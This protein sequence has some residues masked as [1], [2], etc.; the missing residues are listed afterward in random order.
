[1]NGV[2]R[3]WPSTGWNGPLADWLRT[4]ARLRCRAGP[5]LRG[6]PP[7][8][9]CLLPGSAQGA[10]ASLR[11]GPSAHPCA[12]TAAAGLGWLWGARQRSETSGCCSEVLC[13]CRRV[14]AASQ[15]PGRRFTSGIDGTCDGEGAGGGLED[16]MPVSDRDI[17]RFAVS[18]SGQT[19]ERHANG[20]FQDAK[21]C[22][23]G[24]PVRERSPGRA[25]GTPSPR[26]PLQGWPVAARRSL[27]GRHRTGRPGRR[28]AR[29]RRLVRPAGS[30][31]PV[32]LLRPWR[33][34]A[35]RAASR[36]PAWG[37]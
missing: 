19:V 22:P 18:V 20:R 24:A 17:G 27:T 23:H 34:A 1:M 16:E 11:D 15:A 31:H 4:E 10:A 7:A 25:Y 3:E 35:R 36:D 12:D 9:G 14:G 37:W 13:T 2:C 5:S 28:G 29:A 26:A 33:R 8:S 30:S 32:V 6:S 21:Y